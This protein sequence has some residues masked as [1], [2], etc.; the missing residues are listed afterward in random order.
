LKE[1][2]KKR[3]A[4]QQTNKKQADLLAAKVEKAERQQKGKK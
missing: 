2:L 4:G 1:A 3:G